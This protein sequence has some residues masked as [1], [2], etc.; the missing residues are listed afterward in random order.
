MC[1]ERTPSLLVKILSLLCLNVCFRS[2]EMFFC[3]CWQNKCR[4]RAAELGLLSPSLPLSWCWAGHHLL[5]SLLFLVC[6]L[7]WA[8]P[9]ALTGPGLSRSRPTL[10]QCHWSNRTK[11]PAASHTGDTS[12]PDIDIEDFQI[13]VKLTGWVTIG[14]LILFPA[15]CRFNRPLFSATGGFIGLVFVCKFCDFSLAVS[16][17]CLCRKQNI[18]TLTRWSLLGWVNVCFT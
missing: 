15:A 2:L 8:G 11:Q 13:A 5:L 10:L 3:S 6:L 1:F 16:V 17:Q 18:L 4:G 12:G 7:S 9:R 14:S